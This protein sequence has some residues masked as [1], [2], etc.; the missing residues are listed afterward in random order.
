MTVW[1][2]SACIRVIVIVIV[3]GLAFRGDPVLAAEVTDDLRAQGI[4]L[5]PEGLGEAIWR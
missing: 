4:A 5:F 2:P 1:R 3:M